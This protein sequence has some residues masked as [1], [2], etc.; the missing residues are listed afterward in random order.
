MKKRR[1]FRI[2]IAAIFGVN[3]V[4][5]TV[6]ALV[7]IVLHYMGALGTV[8]PLA[9]GVSYVLS[10]TVIGS[11]L[12]AV[13]GRRFFSR[14]LDVA[15][16]L[17]RVAG[18][19]YTARVEENQGFEELDEMARSF[20]RMASELESTELMRNDF[21]ANVSHEFKTPLAAIEGYASLIKKDCPDSQYADEIIAAT[22]RLSRLTG[23]ILLL[24]RLENQT[25]E[26]TRR[27]FR[28]DRQLRDAV[29]MFERQ[30]TEK[31]LELDLDLAAIEYSGSEDLLMHVWQ[32]VI[33]N[34]VKFSPE[35]GRLTVKLEKTIAFVIVTVADSGPGFKEGDERRIFEKF[36]QSDV[37]HSTEGN[38]LGLPLA[39][40]IVALHGGEITAGTDKGAVVKI[41]LPVWK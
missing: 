4:T 27:P 7:L 37:S 35:G 34:A 26:I 9:L 21:I 22:R 19:D 17:N 36:Y 1:L 41:K 6:N 33:G 23:N 3:F 18:G 12:S 38:G 14:F 10:V 15:E 32:N 16:K 2:F 28:L 30:W 24:S 13:V 25:P 20:N 31:N 8:A 11:A 29:L 5:N 39:A 40:K